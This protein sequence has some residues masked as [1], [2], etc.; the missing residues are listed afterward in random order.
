MGDSFTVRVTDHCIK[1]SVANQ[2]RG[3]RRQ[4]M[5]GVLRRE[6]KRGGF[7]HVSGSRLSVRRTPDTRILRNKSPLWLCAR[8]MITLREAAFIIA[9][10]ATISCESGHTGIP[11]KCRKRRWFMMLKRGAFDS[12]SGTIDY[13]GA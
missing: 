4:P 12:L 9:M 1:L 7:Q 3:G 6:G 13:G 8:L 10:D 11:P 5:A 2:S